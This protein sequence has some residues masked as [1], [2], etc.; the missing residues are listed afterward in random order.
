MRY[1]RLLAVTRLFRIILDIISPNFTVED[2]QWRS[3]V[4]D[5]FSYFFTAKWSDERVST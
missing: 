2:R 4:N 5:I 1:H 3:S